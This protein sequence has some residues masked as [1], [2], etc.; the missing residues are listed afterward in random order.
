[1]NSINRIL[2]IV[3]IL[4][5]G[6]LLFVGGCAEQTLQTHFKHKS[7]IYF[8]FSEG[9]SELSKKEWRKRK[10]GKD[11]TLITIMDKERRAGFSVIPV[12]LNS[13]AQMVFGM[14]GDEVEAR[15]AMFLESLHAAGPKRYQ[16]YKLF[17]KGAAL[18]AGFPMGELVF[19]GKN[20]GKELK[21][22][23][24]LVLALPNTEEA[25][26]MFIFTAPMGEQDSFKKDFDFI[27]GTWK[28]K[29]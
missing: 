9:W 21:W 24:V 1:M 16:E 3:M 27:E 20:P 23:R 14:M 25:M 26:I 22:Y 11:R 10:M 5:V 12:A 19:Q 15:V 18:F 6:T 2:V 29:D 13:E 7:G 17:S 8:E 4:S 28:W